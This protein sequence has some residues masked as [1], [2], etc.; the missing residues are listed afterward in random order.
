MSNRRGLLLVVS[1]P[2]GGGKSTLIARLL[3]QIDGISFSI[4]YTTRKPRPGEMHGREYFFISEEDFHLMRKREEF[5]EWAQVYGN[6]YAT[7]RNTVE[8]IL[9]RGED[10]LLDIDVQGA[11]QVRR[12]MPD[13]VL[14]FILPPSFDILASRLRQRA[15][16]AEETIRQRLK[17]ASE[18][19]KA[20]AEFDYCIINDDLERAVQ[21][22]VS[23]TMA[24]RI[25]PRRLRNTVD[26]ILSGF[27]SCE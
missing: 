17:A 3:K 18:E 20:Y 25:R 6:Y 13:A 19:V 27:R 23:V 1:A 4:S 15:L 12:L 11:R 10:V 14:V 24:E 26:A 5:L 9:A 22:L 21:E 8:T 16:D 2:S 7:H